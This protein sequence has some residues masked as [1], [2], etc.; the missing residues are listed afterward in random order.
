MAPPCRSSRTMRHATACTVAISAAHCRQTE[1]W[2]GGSSQSRHTLQIHSRT[3][4]GRP[5]LPLLHQHQLLAVR[6]NARFAPP[7][8][9]PG[10]WPPRIAFALPGRR[11]CF[12]RPDTLDAR[13]RRRAN[14]APF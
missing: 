6:G 4:A 2:S 10:N 1:A 13:G 5:E 9:P 7:S 3:V 12:R 14:A 8:S 11:R